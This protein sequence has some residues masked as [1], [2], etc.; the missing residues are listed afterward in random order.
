MDF[1]RTN[2]GK[3][4]IKMLLPT[5]FGMI[6]SAV[7]IITDGIFVGKGLGSE[8]LAA[9]NFV[10]PL[11][12]FATGIGLM[13]GMGGSVVASIYL[14]KGKDDSARVNMTQA[15][16]A[17]TLFLTIC[18]ALIL[19]NIDLVLRLLGCSEALM[20]LA[21]NYVLGF[22]PFMAVN[23]LLNSCGFFIRLD[24]APRY[25]MFCNIIAA[26][27]NILMDYV[28]IFIFGWGIFGAA[29]ATS[30]GTIIGVAGMLFFLFRKGKQLHFVSLFRSGANLRDALR[31]VIYMGK[32]GISSFLCE[33]AVS[34]LMLCGNYVFV[35]DLG[36]AGVAAFSIA[37]YFFPIVFMLY[38]G[39]A[40]AIQPII[41]YNFGIQAKQRI[42][43]ILLMALGTSI[44]CGMIL[45]LFTFFFCEPIISLFI[46]SDEPAYNLA[47]A[48]L[49]LFSI[50]FIPFAIS[51]T[52]IGY[53]QSIEQ[54]RN[55]TILTLLRGFVF[56]ILCFM[57]IPL[58][59]G[60]NGLWLA[61]PM[62]ELLALGV[63]LLRR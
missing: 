54:I 22:V 48:G 17:S 28:F 7:F 38:S 50:G 37:C 44:G 15:I 14:S 10:S 60:T 5:L 45:S 46:N 56:I 11:W 49:P 4:F 1:G 53:Y 61:M 52:S 8:A 30:L 63:I 51:I 13:Y 47:K 42:K 58:V 3:L 2:P 26:V 12:L 43:S 34:C 20:G 16:V 32:L 18:T 55:A 6:F 62:A 23:G 31:N 40:Q 29:F 39:I 41:S 24:G 27:L 25:A 57:V 59:F 36:D 35:R 33:T 21:R 19:I 9:V